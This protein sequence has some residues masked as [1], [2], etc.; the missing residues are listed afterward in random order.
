M[1]LNVRKN[2]DIG[3][4]GVVTSI[5]SL[6][7]WMKFYN[8]MGRVTNHHPLFFHPLG[9][10]IIKSQESTKSIKY[11]LGLCWEHLVINEPVRV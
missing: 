8:S 3:I 9:D 2:N 10:D 7:K 11:S 6:P 5:F 1:M 4:E